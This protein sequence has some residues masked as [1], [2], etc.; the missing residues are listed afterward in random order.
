MTD[1]WVLTCYGQ[2]ELGA[3]TL[4]RA[5]DAANHHIRDSCPHGP[6]PWASTIAWHQTTLPEL[7]GRYVS[8]AGGSWL[9]HHLIPTSTTG[10]DHPADL[11]LSVLSPWRGTAEPL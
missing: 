11:F 6:M 1:G 3:G 2:L 4:E 7:G 8:S 9:N 5:I 10:Q